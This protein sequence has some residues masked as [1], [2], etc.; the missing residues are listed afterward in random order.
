MALYSTYAHNQKGELQSIL[1]RQPAK[2]DNKGASQ[3][4]KTEAQP[5]AAA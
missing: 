4:F 3:K 2:H 5:E 1:N